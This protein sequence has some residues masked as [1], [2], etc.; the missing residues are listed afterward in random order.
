MNESPTPTTNPKKLVAPNGK[1]II[2][3]LEILHGIAMIDDPHVAGKG[4]KN[5]HQRKNTKRN[6]FGF[7]YAGDTDV[8]WDGQETV[9]RK[10]ERIFVDASYDEW[11][12]SQLKLVDET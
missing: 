8:N 9:V 4:E 6:R 12:E 5:N 11:P 7:E 3:T 1:E 2:G 10:G